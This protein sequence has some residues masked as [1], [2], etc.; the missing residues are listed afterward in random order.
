MK[1]TIEV[2][3]TK[4]FKNGKRQGTWD[5]RQGHWTWLGTWKADVDNDNVHLNGDSL[6]ESPIDGDQLRDLVICT[7]DPYDRP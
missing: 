1:I 4:K 2:V 3:E 6:H 7:D 5:I